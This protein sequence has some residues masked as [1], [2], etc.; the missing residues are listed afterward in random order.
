MEISLLITALPILELHSKLGMD[1]VFE[2]IPC[3]IVITAIATAQPCHANDRDLHSCS[4]SSDFVLF[5]AGNV[6][7]LFPFRCHRFRASRPPLTL[8]DAE[9]CCPKRQAG[10]SVDWW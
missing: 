9:P 7:S 5:A 6:G 8:L 3:L 1:P 4:D 2:V 10:A